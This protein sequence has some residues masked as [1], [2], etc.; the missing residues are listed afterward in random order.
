M[1]IHPTQPLTRF[2]FLYRAARIS[3]IIKDLEYTREILNNLAEETEPVD[4][5]IC[6]DSL[7]L[8]TQRTAQSLAAFAATSQ[9]TAENSTQCQ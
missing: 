5:E 4:F 7:L 1:Q 8:R 6:F 9:T 2:E 3:T